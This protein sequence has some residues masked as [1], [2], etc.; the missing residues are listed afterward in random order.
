MT[1]CDNKHKKRF[2]TDFIDDSVI[3]YAQACRAS[4]PVSFLEDLGLGSSAKAR[5]AVM[6]RSWWGEAVLG[7]CL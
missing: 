3:A 7:G 2:F 4:Q 1:N 6:I 5:I